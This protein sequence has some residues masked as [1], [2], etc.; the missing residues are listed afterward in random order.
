MPTVEHYWSL[1]FFWNNIANLFFAKFKT[2]R[3]GL[4]EWSRELSKLN[5]LIN[6]NNWVLALL[7]DLEEQRQLSERNFRRQL[8][9]H[10]L[11]LLKAKIIYWKLCS[12][13]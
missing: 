10:L 6:N 1:P 12:T 8:K 3:R 5:N 9:T 13:I 4:T 2:L 7:D 11:N